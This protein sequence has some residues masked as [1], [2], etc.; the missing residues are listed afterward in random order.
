MAALQLPS[1]RSVYSG[2]SIP[3]RSEAI[4][5]CVCP[6]WY[7]PKGSVP[8]KVPGKETELEYDVVSNSV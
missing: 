7:H 6:P 8:T 5:S 4:R 3:R 1:S 2:E